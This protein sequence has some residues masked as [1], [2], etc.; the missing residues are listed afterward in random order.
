MQAGRVSCQTPIARRRGHPSAPV[1][2][3]QRGP[4]AEALPPEL[5]LKPHRAHMKDPYTCG[6]TKSE[7]LPRLTHP[8]RTAHRPTDARAPQLLAVLVSSLQRDHLPATVHRLL[9][10]QG[11]T[12]PRE[13]IRPTIC[14]PNA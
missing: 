14:V 10:K 9:L 4:E 13:L 1:K 12:P 8:R 3:V 6:H 2:K 5:G 7:A 11:H